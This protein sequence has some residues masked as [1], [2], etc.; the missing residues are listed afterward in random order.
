MHS[1]HRDSRLRLTLLLLFFILLRP[2][3]A[4]SQSVLEP[5]TPRDDWENWT[6]QPPVTGGLRV[7]IMTNTEGALKDPEYIS[8]TL[9]ESNKPALCVEVSSRDAYY[10]ASLEYDI[11]DV[12]P[13]DVIL[14]FPTRKKSKLADY[15]RDQLAV[16]ASLA[17]ECDGTIGTYVIAEWN[18][19]ATKRPSRG[20]VTVYL[21]SGVT[22]TIAV[23]MGG[24]IEH[25]ADC[26]ELKG[27]ATAFNQRCV[28][29]REWLMPGVVV[30]ILTREAGTKRPNPLPL[31][32][33]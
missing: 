15:D 29:P 3:N 14:H 10:S 2:G 24:K 25:E 33:K 19:D 8:V 21:N 20:D 11:V 4:L 17:D 30:T 18:N 13:G 26:R 5:V 23:G 27:D 31:A 9:P 7:G 32:V 1:Y 12:K 16:L 28:L 22:T 6:G